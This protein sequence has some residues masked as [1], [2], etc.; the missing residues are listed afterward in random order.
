MKK[1]DRKA[2]QREYGPRAAAKYVRAMQKYRRFLKN[3]PKPKA[4]TPKTEPKAAPKPPK[5]PKTES[6][7]TQTTKPK[8]E[9]KPRQTTPAE[10]RSRFFSSS[11]GTYGQNMPTKPKLKS[12]P[13][14]PSRSDFPSGR[15]GASAYSKA[16]KAY[17]SKQNRLKLNLPKPKYDRRG[18][19][20]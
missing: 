12:Q 20:K 17:R 19:R 18:R 7:P 11:S 13:K 4:A 1:P 14:K 2:F 16:L 10:A 5:P 6:K 9:T 8:T 15:S 3:Q